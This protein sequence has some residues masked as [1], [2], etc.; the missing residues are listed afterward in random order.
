MYVLYICSFN[1]ITYVAILFNIQL[2]GRLC[3]HMLRCFSTLVCVYMFIA[4]I[5]YGGKFDRGKL[6]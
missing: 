2:L 5:L 3:L 4:T 6:Y 1:Q